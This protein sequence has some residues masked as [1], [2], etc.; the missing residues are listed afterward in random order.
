MSPSAMDLPNIR[1][2]GNVSSPSVT[3]GSQL[4]TYDIQEV[5]HNVVE[6]TRGSEAYLIVKEPGTWV[7]PWEIH[8]R[9]LPTPRKGNLRITATL[10]E[11][12]NG[13]TA[14]ES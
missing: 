1:P 6:T 8:A 11:Q 4:L 14:E 12:P 3:D 9:N 5:L 7:I 2:P 10:V 13:K